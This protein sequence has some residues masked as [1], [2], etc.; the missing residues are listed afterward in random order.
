MNGDKGGVIQLYDEG[1]SGNTTILDSVA[2][3]EG[4][5]YTLDKE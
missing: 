2:S 5:G 4:E 3:Y 1:F